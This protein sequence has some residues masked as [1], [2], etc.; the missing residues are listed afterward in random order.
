MKYLL[1][2]QRISYEKRNEWLEILMKNPL[3]V[4]LIINENPNERP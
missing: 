2:A 4:H 1:K 3:K